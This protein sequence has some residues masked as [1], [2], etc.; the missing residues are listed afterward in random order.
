[1]KTKLKS[2]IAAA[3]ACVAVVSQA[4][5]YEWMLDT[6]EYMTTPA[7]EWYS[8]D[9]YV[10]AAGTQQDVLDAFFAG[11]DISTLAVE[12]SSLYIDQGETFE[13]FPLFQ[14]GTVGQ[15]NSAFFAAILTEG[16]KDYVFISEEASVMNPATGN[17]Q[18]KFLS[19]EAS[20]K[21]FESTTYSAAG[22]YT[23]AVPPEPSDE[24]VVAFDEATF[25][26][27]PALAV[28]NVKTATHWPWDGKIDVTCDLTG[29]G[30][31]QLSAALTTNGVTVCTATAANL[32]G[33]TTINLD[34]AGGV[35]N[36][37]KFVWNAKADCPADFNSKDTKVKVTAKKVVPP[38]GA[39]PGEFSVSADKKVLFS[40][41]N[42][43]AT[44]DVSG[45]PTAWKFAANQ[46]DYVGK[47]GA[48]EGIGSKAGDVDLFGWSTSSNG[49]TSTTDNYGIKMS[50]DAADYS[51]SFYD[52]GKAV[53]DGSTWRTLSVEEWKY[54]IEAREV[55]GGK[56]EGKSFQRATIKSDATSVYGM[57][58]FPDNYTETA[59]ASY[60]SAEWTSLE[61]LGCVFLP[62]AG[63]RMS[64]YSMVMDDGVGY[65]WSK[66]EKS[67]DN[68]QYL[69]FKSS[70]VRS[71]G[72][73]SRCEGQ[74]VRLV[75]EVK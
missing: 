63:Y 38:A 62:A 10:F 19:E 53:G 14:Y 29:M 73:T 24:E 56:G 2:I 74:S 9:A 65:Y 41:G 13:P 28:A 50:K 22:Y 25:V 23:Q 49:G 33:A 70:T 37:V 51:G 8:G 32:T 1:M 48:N 45:V 52:W 43:V 72:F 15:N 66:S 59:K 26:L 54:L 64:A 21:V 75:T 67:G 27:G 31:V 16:G 12:G 5:G 18:Y 69:N 30:K 3:I 36:G 55:N 39:L 60:T 42:L 68:V 47:N 44:I 61:K 34:A 57:I 58:L 71:D 46:Y 7:D 40:Q 20:A 6:S 4:A 17:G 11:T 35:T